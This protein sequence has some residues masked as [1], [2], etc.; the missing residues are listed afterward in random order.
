MMIK[1][2][3]ALETSLRCTFINWISERYGQKKNLNYQNLDE[4]KQIIILKSL[5]SY[6]NIK[7]LIYSIKFDNHKP[8]GEETIMINE[9]FIVNCRQYYRDK[10]RKIF[11][12][13]TNYMKFITLDICKGLSLDLISGDYMLESINLLNKKEPIW[14]I[15]RNIYESF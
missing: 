9:E 14:S 2:N 10:C 4:T 15:K 5:V 13:D 11:E 7:R 6:N 1:K 8:D 12:I 3:K